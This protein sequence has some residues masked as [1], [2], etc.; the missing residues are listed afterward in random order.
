VVEEQSKPACVILEGA[1][2]TRSIDAVRNRL[3]A[4]LSEHAAIELDCSAAVEVD[5]SLIQLLIAARRSAV[6][7]GKQLTLAQPADGAL[8]AALMQGGF[9]PA[10]GP[11]GDPEAAFWLGT[12]EAS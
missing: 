12:A 6:E 11:A 9:L 7:A 8:R 3:A 2:T 10:V 5:L 4:A 1:L